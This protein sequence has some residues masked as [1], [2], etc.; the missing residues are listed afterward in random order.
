MYDA[1]SIGRVVESGTDATVVRVGLLAIEAA[2]VEIEATMRADV[3]LTGTIGL[4]RCSV[5]FWTVSGWLTAAATMCDVVERIASI[6]AVLTKAESLESDEIGKS[7]AVGVE[8]VGNVRGVAGTRKIH[9]AAS[10]MASIGY[11]VDG[12]CC[13]YFICSRSSIWDWCAAS[14]ARR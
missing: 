4:T 9:W 14:K 12:G 2:L 1:G 3:A 13:G 7:A 6:W 5:R 10:K 11:G 8:S